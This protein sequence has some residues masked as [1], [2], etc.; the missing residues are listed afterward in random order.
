MNASTHPAP[1]EASGATM[2][3]SPPLRPVPLPEEEL[4]E[5]REAYLALE[6]FQNTPE[7]LS[8]KEA[9]HKRMALLGTQKP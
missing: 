3:P 9:L 6:S 4:K 2:P 1:A 5:L 7:H 8:A